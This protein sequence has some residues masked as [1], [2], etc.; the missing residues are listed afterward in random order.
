MWAENPLGGLMNFIQNN[1]G[2][3]KKT[4]KYEILNLVGFRGII[5]LKYKN[6][7]F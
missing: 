1:K 7:I 5:I 6:K 4:I 2:Y 3:N